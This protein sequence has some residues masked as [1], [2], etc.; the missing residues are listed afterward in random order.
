MIRRCDDVLPLN[1]M[2]AERLSENINFKLLS[3]SKYGLAQNQMTDFLRKFRV[4][5]SWL[6]T[7]ILCSHID[8]LLGLHMSNSG[9]KC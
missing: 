3:G 1:D 6:H 4:R 7:V 8:Q 9:G 2:T 5:T